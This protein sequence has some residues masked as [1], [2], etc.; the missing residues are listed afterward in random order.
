MDAMGHDQHI[1]TG[2]IN[3]GPYYGIQLHL[4]MTHGL[5]WSTT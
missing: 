5:A 4:D 1:G 3:T 2:E